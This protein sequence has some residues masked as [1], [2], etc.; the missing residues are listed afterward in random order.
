MKYRYIAIVFFSVLLLLNCKENKTEIETPV[1]A[2]SGGHKGEVTEVLQT[3]QYTYLKVN[4]NGQEKWLAGT[5]VDISQGDEIYFPDGMEMKNW[6]SKELGREFA[7][8]FFVDKI[9]EKPLENA[10]AS[11]MIS[12][13]RPKVEKATISIKP[14]SGSVSIADVYSNK[15]AYQNKDVKVKGQVVKVNNDIMGWNWVH[16]QD[17]TESNGKFDFTVSTHDKV[18]TG[19]VVMF[20][21]IITLDKD[22][23]A[24]Y[25]YDVIMQEAKLV[26]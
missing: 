16:I 20:E 2:H 10:E 14:E 18:K 5:K 19:D 23:G 13:S 1:S 11:K 22:F 17:G 24:G 4:E 26:K 21:G 9:S 6:K 3:T 8:V 25:F 12:G 15:N 7:S